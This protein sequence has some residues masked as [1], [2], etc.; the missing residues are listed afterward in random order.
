MNAFAA[1][2]IFEILIA[3]FRVAASEQSIRSCLRPHVRIQTSA[4]GYF[5][6]QYKCSARSSNRMGA[7]DTDIANGAIIYEIF[8]HEEIVS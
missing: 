5:S 7:I 2:R 4:V 8:G 6:L 1:S 3:A